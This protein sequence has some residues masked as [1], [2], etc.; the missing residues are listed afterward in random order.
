MK[1]ITIRIDNDQQVAQIVEMLSDFDAIRAIDVAQLWSPPGEDAAS[2]IKIIETDSAPMISESRVS[3]Y[4]VMEAHDEGYSV[5]EIRDIYN[6]S[7]YQVEVALEY[8][9]AH[10]NELEPKLK[11]IQ[12]KLAEREKYYRALAAEREQQIP[13]VMTPDR[14]ALKA[15]IE[16]SRRERGAI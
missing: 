13:S 8:I 10:R 6:L 9:K 1:Q 12:I 4:D 5:R 7:F 16:K 11:A 3:V 14:K 2:L 15:L